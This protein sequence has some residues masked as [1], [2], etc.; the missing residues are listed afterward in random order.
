MSRHHAVGRYAERTIGPWSPRA[1]GLPAGTAL[2][3]GLD[4]SR[5]ELI[6]RVV[7]QNP[8]L[9]VEEGEAIVRAVLD[10]IG[11]ALAAGDR[12]ELRD[13]GAFS[14]RGSEARTGRNPRTGKQVA[15]PARA[16]SGP[17]TVGTI[18]RRF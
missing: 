9:T 2:A 15:I 17:L 8:H 3:S 18:R 12:V 11:D 16:W 14:V 13:F 1:D 7:Q 10:R 5:S 6:A 4:M